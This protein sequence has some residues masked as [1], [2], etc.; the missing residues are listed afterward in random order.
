MEK[1]QKE[2][3]E[4]V[5]DPLSLNEQSNDDGEEENDDETAACSP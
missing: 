5:L 4:D 1:K 2:R 3:K